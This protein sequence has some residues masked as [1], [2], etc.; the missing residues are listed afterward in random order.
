MVE[1]LQ[2]QIDTCQY[3]EKIFSNKYFFGSFANYKY[4]S[5]I[6]PLYES[7]FMIVIGIIDKILELLMKNADLFPYSLK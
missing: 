5:N 2:Y 4:P 7:N 6:L 1:Y 3:N